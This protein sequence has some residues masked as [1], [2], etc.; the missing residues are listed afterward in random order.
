M[1]YTYIAAYAAVDDPEVVASSWHSMFGA[2]YNFLHRFKNLLF[3]LI[4]MLVAVA[5][6]NL[7]SSMVMLVQ[8]RRSDIAVLQTIGSGKWLILCSFLGTAWFIA[9]VSLVLCIGLAW[10]ASLIVPTAHEWL[11]VFLG[12][13][14]RDG[15]ALHRFSVVL[16]PADTLNVVWLTLLLVSIGA[17][18]PAW[19]ATRLAPSEVLRDE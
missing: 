5:T 19:R 15:F 9:I 12:V 11:S 13:S 1:N 16:T 18:Y 10:L 17:L 2:L 8:S 4:S 14:L 7:V 6:F 3:L